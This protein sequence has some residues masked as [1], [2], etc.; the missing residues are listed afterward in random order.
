MKLITCLLMM[1]L[2]LTGCQ[3]PREGTE[4][5]QVRVNQTTPEKQ[6]NKQERMDNQSAEEI[7]D[8]LVQLAVNVPGVNDATAIVFGRN[9]IVGIDVGAKLDR[10]RV[11]TIKYTVAEALHED[12]FGANSIVVADPDTM[13]RLREISAD[14]GKGRPV[15]GFA[16]E[17]G[18]IMG[19]W[20]PQIPDGVRP[21]A[22]NPGNNG[23]SNR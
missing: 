23:Q 13:Q 12:P 19:R 16:E 8:R 2:I 20:M 6:E 7:A 3:A 15:S 9:A 17:L 14:I 4:N 11:G 1:G 5:Q 21:N 22:D 10:A 18:D